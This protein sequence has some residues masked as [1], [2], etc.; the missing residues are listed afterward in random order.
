MV[1]GTLGVGTSMGIWGHVLLEKIEI[2]AI[3]NGKF[4]LEFLG[5]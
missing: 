1:G 4:L 3:G 5:A 2:W